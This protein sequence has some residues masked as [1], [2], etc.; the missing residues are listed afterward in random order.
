MELRENMMVKIRKKE[1]LGERET[2]LLPGGQFGVQGLGHHYTGEGWGQ[3][4][5]QGS[6]TWMDKV[7]CA[8]EVEGGD[9]LAVFRFIVKDRG[10]IKLGE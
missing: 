9:L 1:L 8:Q 10:I 6:R 3:Q 5:L 4:A 2:D 7:K